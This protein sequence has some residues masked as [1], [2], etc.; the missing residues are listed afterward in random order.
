MKYF[1]YFSDKELEQIHSSSLRVLETVGI[2]FLYEPAVKLLSKAGCKA[3]GHRVFFRPQLV[4]EQIAKAPSQFTLYA[5]NPAKNVTIG[6]E[7]IAYVPCYGAPVVRDLDQGRR[8]STLNDFTN[9]V[10]LTHASF[11]QDITGGLMV[12]PNDIAP[13][14]R[15]AEMIYAAIRYSDKPF[16]GGAQGA[17]AAEETIAAASIVFGSKAE[18]AARPPFISI[19]GSRAPL[20]YDDT[21][22]S[23]MMTYARDGMPQLVSALSIAGATGPVTMEG[24]L[25]VQNAEVL[26]GIAL[27]QLVREGTP[28]VYGGQST[29]T[30]MRYGTLSVGSP[31][32]AV[33]TAATAQLARFYDLPS[34]SGGAITDAKTCDSQAGSES[35]MGQ[36]MPTLSGINFVLHSAGILETYMVASYEKFILDDEICG[37]CKRIKRGENITQERLAVDLISEVGPGG[38][39]L[40]HAHTFRNFRSEFYQPLIEERGKYGPWYRSGALAMEQRANAKWKEILA[41]YTEPELPPDV[42]RD[43]RQFV[44]RIK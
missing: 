7:H 30:A 13:A 25:V 24:T 32:M 28:V 14:R 20:A 5:R 36:L 27:T 3:E 23:A 8:D 42:A 11:H 17:T 15:A 22:L 26:A 10:K 31:E 21:M 12:E 16:M 34:R 33:N 2:D 39:Y 29:N 4:D 19:L 44:D 38:E 43:L 35:M 18:M 40:T 9:F 1:E 37:M 41:N 6:G